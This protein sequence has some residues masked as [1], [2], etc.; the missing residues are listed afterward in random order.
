MSVVARVRI[1]TAAF[2]FGDAL[3]TVAAGEVELLRL[4]PDDATLVLYLR[5]G[6][7]DPPRFEADLRDD[8]RVVDLARHDHRAGKTLY[9]V[10]WNDTPEDFLALLR[11][12]D[13]SIER[14]VRA[15]GD[16]TFRL[17]VPDRDVLRAFRA[18]CRKGDLPLR[19]DWVVDG[20]RHPSAEAQSHD[21]DEGRASADRPAT[22]TYD[23]DSPATS[24]GA[25]PF[26]DI[27]ENLAEVV[28]MTDP[29]KT[30][31]LY[32][33]PAYEEVWG[34]S[35]ESLYEDPLDFLDAVHP[36]DRERVRDA[37][38]SQASGDYDEEYRIT[39]PDGSRRWIHDRAVPIRDATGEVYR[40]VGIAEDV[41]QQKK[42]E[43]A[44]TAINEVTRDLLTVQSLDQTADLVVRTVSDSLNL[45]L[46]SVYRFD[47]DAGVL[48]PV[49]WSSDVDD[50]LGDLPTFTGAGSL[51]WNAFVHGDT[52]AYADVRTHDK[53]YDSATPI[54]SELIV[55][56]GDYG[57]ILAGDQSIDAFDDTDVEF[58]ELL[59]ANATVALDRV[60]HERE[61]ERQNVRLMELSR[62][63]TVI[64]SINRAIVSA[65][66]R[67]RIVSEVCEQLVESGPY[68]S[69]WVG[70]YRTDEQITIHAA[71][72]FEETPV[73]RRRISVDGAPVLDELVGTA[74]RT[75]AVHVI[76]DLQAA[77]AA[78]AWH[79]RIVDHGGRS[80]A[81]IPLTAG[82]ASYGVLTL[83]TDRPDG[84]DEEDIAVL[85]ELGQTIGR[86]IRAAEIRR[87]LTTETALELEFRI[88]GDGSWFVATSDALDC[89]FD[90]DGVVTLDGGAVLAY[91]QSTGAD[92]E[93]L[94]DRAAGSSS[95]DLRRVIGDGD[96][97]HLYEFRISGTSPIRTL[98]D[99]G[100]TIQSFVAD[101]GTARIGVEMTP[102]TEVRTVLGGLRDV[103]PGAEL[104]GKRELDRSVET[105]QQF[106][107]TLTERLTEKQLNTLRTAYFAGY[108]EWP[109]RSTAEE[110]AD[111]MGISSATLHFH[112]RRA[113]H[114]MFVATFEREY[115]T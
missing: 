100:A 61:L 87:A 64:R 79:E 37:L 101:R 10:A 103:C 35:R 114:K 32:V 16:W 94:A 26:R 42:R 36:D 58:A 55:P 6:A 45:P 5:V 85:R 93:M 71:S 77:S 9:H 109:R 2:E 34:R 41:T 68:L 46:V 13:V 21:G 91:A 7:D 30:E 31:I 38:D 97:D 84:F 12:H 22:A 53:V 102:E 52:R 67:D 39:R 98:L 63:N 76:S 27:V 51:A 78:D 81:A 66:T 96:D 106:H 33:N 20:E 24:G 50:V 3:E 8:P 65:T 105:A 1:P 47:D 60:A 74:I 72:G 15:D 86:A 95:V 14:G 62:L 40:I 11:E 19:T 82:E 49:A 44:L 89:R 43:R 108:F 92:P 29:D 4:V 23:R 88:A 111:S 18:D 69:A 59:A 25:D 73:D 80:V 90:L 83:Y 48:R 54:R 110:I 107:D 56:I 70:E 104:I 113:L 112:L 75:R 17:R 28:W 99:Y 57:V 115:D